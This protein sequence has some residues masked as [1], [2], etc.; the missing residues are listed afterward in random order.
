MDL[1]KWLSILMPYLRRFY[2]NDGMAFIY[3]EVLKKFGIA[4]SNV[5]VLYKGNDKEEYFASD[6]EKYLLNF[7]AY[8]PCENWTRI[9]IYVHDG[10]LWFARRSVF[11]TVSTAHYC[12]IGSTFDAILDFECLYARNSVIKKFKQYEKNLMRKLYCFVLLQFQE[13]LPE[14]IH[15]LKF[16]KLSEKATSPRRTTNRSVGCDLQSAEDCTILPHGCKTV[17]MDIV[18]VPHSG[19]YPRIAQDSGLAL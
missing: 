5:Y 13:S 11:G 15:E 7:Q 4:C 1:N 2:C 18:L 8:W 6:L 12:D 10:I 9:E 19:V 17:A 16:K 3:N 14:A